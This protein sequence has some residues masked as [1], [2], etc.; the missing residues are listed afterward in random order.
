M[1]SHVPP[2][3]PLKKKGVEFPV[4]CNVHSCVLSS[5]LQTRKS[6][7]DW[8][9]QWNTSMFSKEVPYA[10][11]FVLRLLA[12]DVNLRAKDGGKETF[13][14]PSCQS[15]RHQSLAFRSGLFS[16]RK[17]G[18]RNAWSIGRVYIDGVGSVFS[19]CNIQNNMDKLF[20]TSVPFFQIYSK[21]SFQM[22]SKF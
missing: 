14:F 5:V 13:F 7:T 16:Q 8:T 18:K 17:C 11:C 4:N 9:N 6:F 10:S 3:L 2:S 22:Y 20:Q 19:M 15:I 21:L 12:R 1:G